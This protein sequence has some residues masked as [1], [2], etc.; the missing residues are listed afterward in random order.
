MSIIRCHDCQRD[1]DSDF[2]DMEVIEHKYG[3]IELCPACA[4]DRMD[5]QDRADAAEAKAEQLNA[6][7]AEPFR[8]ILNSFFKA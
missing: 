1:C 7:V 6:H 2:I 3:D 5:E 4:S 8:S